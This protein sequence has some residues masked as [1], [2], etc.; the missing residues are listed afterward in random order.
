MVKTLVRASHRKYKKNIRGSKR[1]K[2]GRII[3]KSKRIRLSSRKRV[4][5]R[6][7]MR[8]KRG[9]LLRAFQS[10]LLVEFKERIEA[11]PKLAEC[12]KNFKEG[13]TPFN[14]KNSNCID[15]VVKNIPYSNNNGDSSL[16]WWLENCDENDLLRSIN[17]ETKEGKDFYKYVLLKLLAEKEDGYKPVPYTERE[18]NER[19]H[20]HRI[21]TTDKDG[22]FYKITRTE[23]AQEN[24]VSLKSELKISNPN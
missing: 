17:E 20:E 1:T 21:G 2:R 24:L 9:G 11:I 5:M 10:D 8:N 19:F 23:W 14:S 6:R 18:D 15:D 7:H 16:R 13:K 12:L 4:T 22:N 3:K